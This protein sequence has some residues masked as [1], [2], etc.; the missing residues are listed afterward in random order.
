MIGVRKENQYS[1]WIDCIKLHVPVFR[2]R[3]PIL[4]NDFVCTFAKNLNLTANRIQNDSALIREHAGYFYGSV[5]L[6]HKLVIETRIENTSNDFFVCGVIGSLGEVLDKCVMSGVLSSSSRLGQKLLEASKGI[7]MHLQSS[8]KEDRFLEY[9]LLT[10]FQ[11]DC[12]R[13]VV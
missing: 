4:L 3:G 10:I 8:L 5:A 12:M 6:I 2:A 9:T 11:L 1:A 13:Q 7:L